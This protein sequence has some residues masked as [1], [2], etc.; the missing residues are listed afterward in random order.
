MARAITRRSALQVAAFGLGSLVLPWRRARAAAPAEGEIETYGL[1]A[2]GDLAMP[3]DFKHFDYVNPDAPKGGLLSLQITATGGN[4]NFDTFD[5]LNMFSK[6]GDGAAGMTSTFD[7]LMTATGDEPDAVYGLVA[8]AVRISADKLSYRFLLRPEARFHDGSKLTAADVAFSIDILKT[9]AHPTFSQLLTD[10]ESVAAEA[11]DVMLVR[12][13]PQRSRDAHL[14]V[15]GMPIF[16]KAYW[17]TRDFDAETTEPPLGSG[18]YKVGH[19]EQGRFIEFNRVKDYWAKDLPVNVGTNNFERLRFEYYRDRDVAF[20]AFKAGSTNYH[21]EYT[22]RLW[23]VGYDFPAAREGRVKKEALHNGAPT[24]SQG[25]YFN[26]RREQF[27]D[28][29]IREAIGLAFDF[30][31]TNK[32]IMYS[33]YKRVVSYFENSDM[34]AKGKPGPEELALLEPFRGK[35]PDGVFGEVYVPPVSDGSGSDRQLLRRAND[36]LL[37]AGCKREGSAIT[38]PSGKPFTIEFLDSSEALQPH[39]AP[40]EQNLR[41]LGIDAR[42]RIVDAAQYKARTENFDFDVVTAAFGG[43]PTPGFELRIFFGSAAA[44]Q[45]GSRNLCGVADPV[46]DALIEKIGKATSRADLNTDCRALDRVLRAA[47]YWI[48]MWYRD[49]SLLAYWDAF[50]RPERQPRL[51][52]GAPDTWWWDDQKAKKIGL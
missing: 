26:T 33:L 46:V 38:L 10:V 5:T 28:P 40:F 20:E 19:F 29:R 25:W 21:E 15:A 4:Q 34:E 9:K 12:F 39:T 36:L 50:S 14:I 45:V 2:F 18:P 22:S 48:P 44:A 6:R 52:T 43:N 16:S 37:A 24:P 7:N 47:Y 35:V 3:A 1:S 8:R 13:I 30:E 41:R 32:N 23:A 31:W 17:S 11:D 49:D 27:K 51:G 42:S